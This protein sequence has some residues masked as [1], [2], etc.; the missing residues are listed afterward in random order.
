MAQLRQQVD[1]VGNFINVILEANLWV[2]SQKLKTGE[3]IMFVLISSK[4]K[5]SNSGSSSNSSSSSSSTSSM[6]DSI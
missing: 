1:S 6:C 3:G 2:D 5:S 4:S